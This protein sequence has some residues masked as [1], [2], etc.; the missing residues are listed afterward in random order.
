MR[1]E[2]GESVTTKPAPMQD[3]T[4]VSNVSDVGQ[5]TA[6]SLHNQAIEKLVMQAAVPTQP[7]R[8]GMVTSP[9]VHFHWVYD[10]GAVAGGIGGFYLHPTQASHVV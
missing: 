5:G 9:Q 4:R 8:A 3:D 6:L 7:V 10:K 1:M 2:R